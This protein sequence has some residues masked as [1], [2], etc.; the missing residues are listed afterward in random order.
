[1]L[2]LYA[3]TPEQGISNTSLS[4]LKGICEPLSD[5]KTRKIRSFCFGSDWLLTMAL[6]LLENQDSLMGFVQQD[7][8][9]PIRTATIAV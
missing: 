4:K 8:F 7:A 1:M 5:R 6:K 3:V 9:I 2:S